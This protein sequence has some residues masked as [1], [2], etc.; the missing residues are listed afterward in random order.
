MYEECVYQIALC[1]KGDELSGTYM[2][3]L[4]QLETSAKM[5]STK[6]RV[7][8]KIAE[9]LEPE[10]DEEACRLAMEVNRLMKPRGVAYSAYRTCMKVILR[11]E[12]IKGGDWCEVFTRHKVRGTFDWKV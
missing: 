11:W 10:E 8:A 6:R 4:R 3:L 12:V 9:A 2:D 7:K 5:I 1:Y